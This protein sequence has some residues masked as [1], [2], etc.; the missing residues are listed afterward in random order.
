MRQHPQPNLSQIRGLVQ[1]SQMRSAYRNVSVEVHAIFLEFRHCA[2]NYQSAHGMAHETQFEVLFQGRKVSFNLSSQPLP[3]RLYA[4]L[5][6]ANIFHTYDY[7]GLI[8]RF[9]ETF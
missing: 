1:I 8:F 9:N 4:L 2:S 6:P 3:H 5:S 7:G